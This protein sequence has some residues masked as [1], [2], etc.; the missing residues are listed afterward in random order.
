MLH[1]YYQK[2]KKSTTICATS[3]VLSVWGCSSLGCRWWYRA[4]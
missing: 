2:K 3:V 4:C 1:W